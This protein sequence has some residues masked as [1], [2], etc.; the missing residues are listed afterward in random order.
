MRERKRAEKE[1][2]GKRKNKSYREISNREIDR[3]R[4]RK[5][6]KILYGIRG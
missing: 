5:I 2:E 6:E 4:G 3:K 1:R